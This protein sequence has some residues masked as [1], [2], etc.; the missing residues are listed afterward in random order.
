[1]AEHERMCFAECA[2]VATSDVQLHFISQQP[3]SIDELERIGA[4]FFG[5]SG[6]YS[7]LDP[8]QWI[9]ETIELM[10]KVIDRK[11]P[12]Y[13]SCF[14]F[15]GLAKALGGVVVHDD[16]LAEMGSF[17]IELTADGERDS[18][19]SSLPP[20]FWAQEG[21]HDYVKE[22]PEGVTLLATGDRVHAQAFR[23]NDAPFWASQFHPELTFERTLE[24]FQYYAD[25]YLAD[26]EVSPEDALDKLKGG[27]NSPEVPELL[28][29]LVRKQF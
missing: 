11:I 18:L 8:H 15:Q 26:D 16:S 9:A 24:R 7:V 27:P 10:L 23:V 28:A 3:A 17:Q 22:L 25:H 5:G 14:G 4:V 12:A 29:R 2:R 6:A 13:A 21:H 1:M 20:T 19:F